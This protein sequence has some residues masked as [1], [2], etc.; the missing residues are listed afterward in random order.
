MLSGTLSV[1]NTDPE[2]LAEAKTIVDWDQTARL[3]SKQKAT[4]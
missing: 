1:A 3:L 2:I 4:G